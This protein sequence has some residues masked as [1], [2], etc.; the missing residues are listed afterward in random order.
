MMHLKTL[1]ICK[2][3]TIKDTMICYSE[4][5][6][7]FIKRDFFFSDISLDELSKHFLNDF[8][9][10]DIFKSNKIDIYTEYESIFQDTEYPKEEELFYKYILIN[11]L[12]IYSSPYN[13]FTLLLKKFQVF[14][15][16]VIDE[17]EKLENKIED[18]EKK[19]I[20][21]VE[22]R[23]HKKH[24]KYYYEKN[25]EIKDNI[26]KFISIDIYHKAYSK[27]QDSVNT[28]L[29]I[30]KL[31]I[32]NLIRVASPVSEF[33]K[34]KPQYIENFNEFIYKF[35]FL[36]LGG[37]EKLMNFYKDDE[38]KFMNIIKGLIENI[39]Q[40]IKDLISINHILSNRKEILETIFNHFNKNDYISINNMLPLQI[41]GL[42][43]DFCI[44]L[45]I[46]EKSIE[47]SSLNN[48]LEKIA[49]KSKDK[50]LSFWSYEYFTFKFPI[51]RN[52]VSHG[53]IFEANN[54]LQAYYLLLDLY[55]VIN[56][57]IDD[58]IELNKYIQFLN[59]KITD[60][61]ILKLHNFK[62]LKV[63][64]FY[65]IDKII[66]KI[67]IRLKSD[68][69]YN[70]LSNK[71]NTINL[72]DINDFKNNIIFLKVKCKNNNF[73]KLIKTLELKRNELKKEKKVRDIKLKKFIDSLNKNATS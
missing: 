9:D 65:K 3:K 50:N 35:G 38:E 19:D 67:I 72:D 61:K 7:N 62:D 16:K 42:F 20:L 15:N 22:G 5:I 17:L 36:P 44:L 73:T 21:T 8:L 34:F 14:L 63:P 54:E 70:F 69:F 48:K 43:Y 40:E 28:D 52:K 18:Y 51:I 33:Y 57:I 47:I 53:R 31:G 27:C 66:N 64:D 68:E 32:K 1:P 46:S 26:I 55:N 60:E 37:I 2:D 6:N 4:Y 13:N 45:G 24:L 58:K 41:E 25:S 23:Y 29:L 39:S 11:Y 12:N 56:L 71:I 30:D 49:D 10:L 59:D